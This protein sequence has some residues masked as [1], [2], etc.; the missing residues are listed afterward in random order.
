MPFIINDHIIHKKKNNHFRTPTIKSTDDDGKYFKVP[1]DV[2]KI[3]IDN[4]KKIYRDGDPRIKRTTQFN[5]SNDTFANKKIETNMNIKIKYNDNISIKNTKIHM[6]CVTFDNTNNNVVESNTPIQKT[7]I[8]LTTIPSRLK[9]K[10]IYDVL[11]SLTINQDVKADKIF[12]SVCRKYLRNFKNNLNGDDL[13]VILNDIE[14]RYKN[15]KTIIVND[16]GPSTKLLGLLEYN[17]SENILKN[18]DQIIIVDDDIIYSNKLVFSHKMCYNVY[19]CDVV[20]VDSKNIT[21]WH[22]YKYLENDI[23][24]DDNYNG[25]VYGWLSFSVR[26][27][28][29][30]NINDYYDKMTLQYP[31]MIFHDDLLFSLYMYE[32]NLYVVKNNFVTIDTDNNRT[33]IDG[34]DSLRDMTINNKSRQEIEKYIY[35]DMNIVVE[36]DTF[37]NKK[38]NYKIKKHIGVRSNHL[39]NKLV[40]NTHIENIHVIFFY[41][42]KH[43]MLMTVTTFDD[44]LIGNSYDIEMHINNELYCVTIDVECSRFSCILHVS[45]EI[46]RKPYS[47]IDKYKIMQTS[48]DGNASRNK[49]YSI[50]SVLNYSPEYEYVYFDNDDVYSYI[51]DNFSQMVNS[52][53]KNLVPG[54]YISDLFRYCYM[55]LNG[56]VYLDCK[57]ILYI[58]LCDFINNIEASKDEIDDDIYVKDTID[59]YA[60]NAIMVVTRKNLV[61]EKSIK[62]SVYNI[63]K[64]N[65]EK[66]PLSITGPGIF[67]NIID[68]CYNKNYKYRYFNKHVKDRP[69]LSL[70]YDL[71]DNVV[72]K[73]TYFGYYDENNYWK[74]NHYHLLWI[75]KNV[76]VDDLSNKYQLERS[77]DVT[78]IDKNV[79]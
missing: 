78:I 19:L 5:R 66:N 70:I 62:V 41:I 44:S 23:L 33:K 3:S 6:N 59:N 79:K 48:K 50:M 39:I 40:I 1:N 27:E 36:N 63:L 60:Y 42:T 14:D 65:Y 53:I 75:N 52:A 49:Y 29:I 22:P 43:K 12:L 34:V 32:N 10:D 4:N 16:N 72:I 68:E 54:A 25:F 47:N 46:E 11:D 69:D 13:D 35:D 67:G 20:A 58:P 2:T 26:Y 51:E 24:Y 9:S 64:N 73:N 38:V 31:E 76:Y 17:K 18:D 30:K 45:D 7:Y 21:S 77:R 37:V 56:G 61:I 8:S 15:V 57:K 28:S 71:N 55:Y 74:K